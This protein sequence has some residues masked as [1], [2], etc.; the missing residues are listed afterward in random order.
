MVRYILQVLKPMKGIHEFCEGV[1]QTLE[2]GGVSQRL[3]S[4]RIGQ[5]ATV[6]VCET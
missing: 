6:A 2:W 5:T 4:E 1:I 3:D